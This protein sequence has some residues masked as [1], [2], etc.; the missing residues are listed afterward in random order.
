MHQNAG[1]QGN[2]TPAYLRETL[3]LLRLRALRNANPNTFHEKRTR[4][5]R[6]KNSFFPNAVCLWNNTKTGQYVVYKLKRESSDKHGGL[7]G[8]RLSDFP[9]HEAFSGIH[10]F[11]ESPTDGHI[12]ITTSY[13]QRLVEFDPVT[14][15]FINHAM[16]DG[17]YPHT[18]RVDKKD[19]VWFTMALSN[20]VAMFDRADKEFTMFD[21]PSRSTKAGVTVSAMGTILKLM[22]WGRKAR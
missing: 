18:V 10:S 22:D 7:M 9:K 11:A 15:K 1:E 5:V 14:K 16:D 8:E 21:L 20:Q 17:Y 3:P 4:K 19:R 12:F 13:Q 6:Y 2:H